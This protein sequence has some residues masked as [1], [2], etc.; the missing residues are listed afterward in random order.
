LRFHGPA[1]EV[2]PYTD[3]LFFTQNVGYSQIQLRLWKDGDHR[4]T[5]HKEA[6]A[7]GVGEFFVEFLKE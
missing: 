7:A 4:L 3:S 6:I 5:A 1:D 2:V